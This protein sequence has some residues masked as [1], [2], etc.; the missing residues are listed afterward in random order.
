MTNNLKWI[1]LIAASAALAWV[2]VARIDLLAPALWQTLFQVVLLCLLSLIILS[3]LTRIIKAF[4]RHFRS[5]IPNAPVQ[6]EKKDWLEIRKQKS[7]DHQQSVTNDKTEDYVQRIL[8]PRKQA[9]L[10][11]KEEKF[12][13]IFP[14]K[15]TGNG[16]VLGGDSESAQ[17]DEN[18]TTVNDVAREHRRLPVSVQLCIPKPVMA[19]QKIELLEEP[20]AENPDAVTIIIRTPLDQ[21]L[22]RRFLKT[23]K[24]Q[25]V[26]EYMTTLGF[27]QAR[28]TLSHSYPR[29]PL[30]NE[31]DTTLQDLK[32]QKKTVLNIEERD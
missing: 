21:R 18:L 27:D 15:W 30:S 17:M 14:N 22:S 5:S 9:K 19:K 16:K 23:C 29:Q 1:I 6:T 10:Q 31:A 4:L 28:Y 3:L 11:K 2:S 13:L 32:F 24:F 12:Q 20:S 25:V 7:R 26:L 8:V